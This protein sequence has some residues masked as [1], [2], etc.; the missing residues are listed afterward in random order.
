MYRPRATAAFLLG[1]AVAAP[2]LLACSSGGE[3][4]LDLAALKRA[5]VT[6]SA[7]GEE[8]WS[9]NAVTELDQESTPRR[10][11]LASATGI[12]RNC[13]AA[14]A[15]V[16]TAD[17]DFVH[18]VSVGFTGPAETRYADVRL[19][20]LRGPAELPVRLREV[21]KACPEQMQ[22]SLVG[23]K[24]SVRIVEVPVEPAGGY[25]IQVTTTTASE[26]VVVDLAAAVRGDT[27]I[28]V[29]AVGPDA[30]ATTALRTTLFTEQVRRVERA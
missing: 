10:N 4:P 5:L 6:V 25:G 2:G 15:A 21:T 26:A 24:G 19:A 18:A 23:E 17:E 16:P 12:P 1:A 14:L 11:P 3:A 13:Q 20:T 9:A 22:A 7:I 29:M 28:S 30:K 27:L 8:G